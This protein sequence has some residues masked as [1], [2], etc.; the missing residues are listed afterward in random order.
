MFSELLPYSEIKATAQ[1]IAK[2][3]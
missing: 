3:C 2:Y 1:S